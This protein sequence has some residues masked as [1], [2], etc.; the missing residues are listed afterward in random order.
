MNLAELRRS[1]LHTV[2]L[3]DPSAA[4]KEASIGSKALG[5]GKLADACGFDPLS[6]VDQL[7]VAIPEE[8]DKGELGV[9]AR[10]TVS[11]D[12]LQKC[13]SALA[14]QRGGKVATKDVGSFAV[15]E[16]S[17]SSSAEGVKPR[18]AYGHGGLLVAGRGT[19]FD[20]MLDAADGKKPGLKAA[21]AHLAMRSSLTNR[22]GWRA[23]TLVVTAL[24]P[25]QLRDRLKDEMG[26]EIGSKDTSQKIMAGVLGV[27][28]VGLALKAGERGQNTDL[29][30]ELSCDNP[31]GCEAVEK[32]V[33]KKR[34]DWGKELTF[35]MVGLG[36][37]LDSIDVKRDGARLRVTATAPADAL[38]QT[39]DRII[40]LKSRGA[41]REGDPPSFPGLARESPDETIPA[42]KLAPPSGPK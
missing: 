39:I 11:G 6:R 8:G 41:P 40:R 26:A 16:D 19:W 25:R 14:D 15:I 38:A 9:A 42:K 18:L 23:P 5:I 32:L 22:D 37:L 17:S 28:S 1:P 27:S 2:L 10:V 12:E 31:E 3:G 13:T 21:A 35:R 4:N 7:A 30:I 34:L 29:A 33:L 20:A 24:L 36:P